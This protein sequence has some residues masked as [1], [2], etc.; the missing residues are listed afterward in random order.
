VLRAAIIALVAFSV[1]AGLRATDQERARTAAGSAAL[2]RDQDGYPIFT[3]SGIPDPFIQFVLR[4]V[5]PIDPVEYVVAGVSSCEPTGQVVG[6]MLWMQ[7]RVAP[8]PTVCGAKWRIYVGTVVPT[9]L[10]PED[11]YSATLAVVQLR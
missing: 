5:P 11:R 8:R 9:D 2:P 1:L 7:F 4:R 6:R 10:P 3:V